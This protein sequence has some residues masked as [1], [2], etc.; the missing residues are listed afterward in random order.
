M[1][2]PSR[3]EP[4]RDVLIDQPTDRHWIGVTRQRIGDPLITLAEIMSPVF[5]KRLA[6]ITIR[7]DI[8]TEVLSKEVYI[9]DE[10]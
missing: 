7:Q 9:N 3:K 8:L 1:S 6:S 5:R 10:N 4:S 2:S